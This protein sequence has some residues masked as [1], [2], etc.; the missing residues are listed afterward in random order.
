M[1]AVVLLRDSTRDV[2]L[3]QVGVWAS[4]GNW[5]RREAA[6]PPVLSSVKSLHIERG[7]FKADPAV[8][9]SWR[10]SGFWYCHTVSS[11]VATTKPC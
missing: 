11:D 4:E 9:F 6:H 7:F 8:W 2:F 10:L 5:G 1:S 3:L